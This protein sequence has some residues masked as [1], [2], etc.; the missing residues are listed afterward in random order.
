MLHSPF[1]GFD[2]EPFG[3][4]EHHLGNLGILRVLGVGELEKHAEREKGSL[5]GLDGRPTGAEGVETDGA[6]VT[7][8]S[9][10]PA[11]KAFSPSLGRGGGRVTYSL[12]ADVGVPDLGVEFDCRGLE[13]VVGR[14]LDVDL[15]RAAGVGC[16]GRARKGA[17]EV[18]HIVVHDGR[19]INAR[20]ITV[21]LD[22]AELFRQ[23]AY[24]TTGGRHVDVL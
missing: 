20:V 18:R 4:V 23:T 14:D 24:S 12:A 7:Q 22:V 3:V 1:V 6:L 8:F 19:R 2:S 5:D 10:S 9:Q 11:Q 21:G 16:V 17:L 13:G 15:E